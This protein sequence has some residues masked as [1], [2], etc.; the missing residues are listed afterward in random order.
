M[1]W[2]IAIQQNT[3]LSGPI[4]LKHLMV[5][6]D[7]GG[8]ALNKLPP[9]SNYCPNGVLEFNWR[10]SISEYQFKTI[11][12]K[13]S[14]TN[15]SLQVD[16]KKLLMGGK[17][18]DKMVDVAMLLLF[19]SS[20]VNDSLPIEVKDRCLI[21]TLIGQGEELE[22]FAR[23]NYIRV[24][25]QIKLPT[26]VSKTYWNQKLMTDTDVQVNLWSN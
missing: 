11:H 6:S 16:A 17:F 7:L 26:S 21:G 8:E 12:K 14:L 13:C 19:G 15:S 20:G 23:E 1:A 10:D 5:M 22:R 18:N 4:F 25:R 2:Q 9:L 24:S 3:S